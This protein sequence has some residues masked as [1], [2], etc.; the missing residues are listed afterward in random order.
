MRDVKQRGTKGAVFTCVH[1]QNAR[2]PDDGADAWDEG[3]II[4]KVAYSGE[5][6]PPDLPRILF[7]RL[8]R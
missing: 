5:P 3:I 4:R 1:V 6:I 8:H 7:R 2:N